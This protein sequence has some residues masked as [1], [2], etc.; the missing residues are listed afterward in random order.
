MTELSA[1]QNWFVAAGALFTGI[2]TLAGPYV[3]YLTLR[4]SRQNATIARDIRDVGHETKTAVVETQAIASR[5]EH[6]TNGNIALIQKLSEQRADARVAAVRAA[7]L[8]PANVA[9]AAEQVKSD[10]RD[11][12]DAKD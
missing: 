7:A 5:V 1:A 4:Q 12:R 2:S 11:A 6:A 10:A 8:E 9:A 3:A